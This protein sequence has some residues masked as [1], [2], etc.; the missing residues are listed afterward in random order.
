MAAL[1]FWHYLSE[2][3]P[4]PS[5]CGRPGCI[6]TW[7]PLCKCFLFSWAQ[8]Q[9]R[10]S[11]SFC[12]RLRRF[13]DLFSLCFSPTKV[14]HKLHSAS[15][16]SATI[17]IIVSVVSCGPSGTTANTANETHYRAVPCPASHLTLAASVPLGT[18]A[19][20]YPCCGICCLP[21]LKRAIRRHWI[22]L[23]EFYF[24]G[25]VLACH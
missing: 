14:C 20:N 11:F 9:P 23:H 15:F 22:L 4:G 18:R 13:P 1:P 10:S 5:S 7:C 8:K 25:D 19:E 6:V 2:D 16:P 24:G 21:I 12:Y 17:C 3:L